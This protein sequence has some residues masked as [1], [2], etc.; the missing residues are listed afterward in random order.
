MKSTVTCP[1]GVK[2]VTG[3]DYWCHVSNPSN[4]ANTC[5]GYKIVSAGRMQVLSNSSDRCF[6]SH[7]GTFPGST[8]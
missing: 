1:S 7:G 3:S 8:S 6:K 5:F 2:V 4:G